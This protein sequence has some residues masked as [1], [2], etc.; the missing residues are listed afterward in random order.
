MSATVRTV[1]PEEFLRNSEEVT[2]QPLG[3]H[4]IMDAWECSD[5]I[6]SVGA[7]EA[8]LREAVTR[9]RAT[10]ID[11]LVHPFTPHGVSGVAVIAESHIAVHTWPEK[12]YFSLDVFTCGDRAMPEAVVEVFKERFR[13]RRSQIVELPRGRWPA[14]EP[15]LLG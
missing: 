2:M 6:D 14:A 7:V 11:I 12:A 5:T 13:P 3:K 10:L 9:S 15:A 8:S 1:K 4:I